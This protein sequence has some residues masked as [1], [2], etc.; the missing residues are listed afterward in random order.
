MPFWGLVITSAGFA[1]PAII[2]FRKARWVATTSCCILTASS[3]AYHGTTHHVA[4]KVDIALAHSIGIGW[5]CESLRRAICIHRFTDVLTC[6]MAFGS[7]A[8]YFCKSR[9]NYS[10][11]SAIWHMVFHCLSQGTWC[12]YLL[13]SC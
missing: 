5:V 13:K 6:G 1:I 8:V 3:L 9:N 7:V 4:Q 10:T 2:A 11:S 12:V